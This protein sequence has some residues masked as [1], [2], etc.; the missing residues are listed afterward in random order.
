MDEKLIKELIFKSLRTELTAEEYAALLAWLEASE[1][2][3]RL[4]AKVRDIDAL[5]NAKTYSSSAKIVGIWHGTRPQRFRRIVGIAVAAAV[6]CM[7]SALSARYFLRDKDTMPNGEDIILISEDAIYRLSESAARDSEMSISDLLGTASRET[8]GSEAAK[9]IRRLIVPRGKTFEIS[10]D[11]GT[12]VTLNS[13]SE[14]SFPVEFDSHERIVE[15]SGEAFFDV[16]KDGGRKFKVR[17]N[18][19]E[20]T[21]LGTQF[22]VSAYADNNSETVSLVDGSVETSNGR[23]TIVLIPGQ[24]AIIRQGAESVDV[25]KFNPDEVLGWRSGFFI[26][27]DKP[28]EMVLEALERWYDLTFEITDEQLREI[29]VFVKLQRDKA[30]ED[31]LEALEAMNKVR[32]VKKEKNVKVMP[33]ADII[34]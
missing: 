26:F 31:I 23:Q 32:F 13:M 30:P 21:V 17:T 12:R 8:T 22:N 9:G 14:L 1:K 10:L 33:Y 29:S 5:Q 19:S 28:L 4:Y 7:I 2:N 6:V 24:Q 18:G 15:L 3:K 27:E 25:A 11:D 16:A 20:V 34:N